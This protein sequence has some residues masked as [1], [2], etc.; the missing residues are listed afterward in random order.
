MK[1]IVGANSVV[2]HHCFIGDESLLQDRFWFA[3][4]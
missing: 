4:Y 2:E 3:S 1:K